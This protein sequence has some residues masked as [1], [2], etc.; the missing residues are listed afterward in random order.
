MPKRLIVS[1][2]GTWQS[3]QD[4]KPPEKRRETNVRRLHE[5]IAGE[6]RDKRGD[7][8]EG[9]GADGLAQVAW[10]DPGVGTEF[11]N[12]IRGGLFG[13]GLGKNI[14]Q[15]Y[16]FL[17]EH[18][19]AGDQVFLFGFS[20]GAYTARSLVGL[21]RKTG[22][23]RKENVS[24]AR[25]QEAYDIYRRRDKHADPDHAVEFRERHSREIRI[26]FLGVWDTVGA[27]GIP[28]AAFKGFNKRRHQFHDVSLSRIVE[29]ACHAV[30]IDEHRSSY[31][32]S[33]WNPPADAVGQRME[34]RWFVGAHSDVGGG[35]KEAGLSR[36]SL[37]W[38]QTKAQEAGLTFK[39]L[40]ETVDD[41]PDPTDSYRKFLGGLY[42]RLKPEFFRDIGATRLGHEV[43]DPSVLTKHGVDRDYR[44]QNLMTFMA[45]S[46]A[47]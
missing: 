32:V 26:K 36:L 27:L 35:S 2:D 1:F 13:R 44:P 10:Y 23:L 16:R 4:D 47:G 21:I 18:C 38:M 11:F 22:L 12:R 25:I 43:L 28:I 24:K 7:L 9:R 29:S 34:Q 31:D 45:L 37:K 41:L 6:P 30:A 8:V 42:K 20:R 39:G 19:D 15:G 3:P 33:L 17:A 14:R 40:V 46:G 5:S